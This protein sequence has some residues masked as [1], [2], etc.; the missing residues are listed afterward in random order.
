MLAFPSPPPHP[1][2]FPPPPLDAAAVGPTWAASHSR[3]PGQRAASETGVPGP[4]CPTRAHPPRRAGRDLPAPVGERSV[5]PRP[6]PSQTCACCAGAAL[7]GGMIERWAGSEGE[8]HHRAA[9]KCKCCLPTDASSNGL[10]SP[11][12]S[13]RAGWPQ[14]PWQLPMRTSGPGP[15]PETGQK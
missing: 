10:S 6:S 8:W 9:C 13:A 3:C 11:G 15:N 14:P 4:G 12:E 5:V 1:P 7:E 2:H